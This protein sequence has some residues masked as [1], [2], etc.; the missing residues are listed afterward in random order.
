M[1][2]ASAAAGARTVGES[3]P[4]S[5]KWGFPV[6]SAGTIQVALPSE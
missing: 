2:G 4:R 5:S 6:P 1:A 3:A